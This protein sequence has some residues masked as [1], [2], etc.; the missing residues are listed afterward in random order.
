MASLTK[1]SPC[2]PII[3]KFSG[4]DSGIEP[5]PSKVV[6]TGIWPFSASVRSS[7]WAPERMM[8]WP[9]RMTGR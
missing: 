7:S 3:R 2:M 1:A 5:I 8:P 9:A 6:E 4:C